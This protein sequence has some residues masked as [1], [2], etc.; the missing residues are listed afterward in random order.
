MFPAL[1]AGQPIALRAHL[2]AAVHAGTVGIRIFNWRGGTIPRKPLALEDGSGTPYDP[3]YQPY[4]D[5]IA[6][7]GVGPSALGL[8]VDPS[9]VWQAIDPDSLALRFTIEPVS[10]ELGTRVVEIALGGLL[11]ADMFSGSANLR[12]DRSFA[13][14]VVS[15]DGD[16]A[17]SFLLDPKAVATL[18]THGDWFPAPSRPGH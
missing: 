13:C 10:L 14:L 12:P 8:R 18:V 17:H 6:K 11:V 2:A 3:D 5:A 15:Q 16:H 9:A 1:H 4:V 7:L